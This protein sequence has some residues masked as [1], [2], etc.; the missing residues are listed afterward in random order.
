[1]LKELVVTFL[2]GLCAIFTVAEGSSSQERPTVLLKTNKGDIK[3]ELFSDKAPN[4]VQNFLSYVKS[5][6]YNGT[7]FHRVIDGFMIQGGGMTKEMKDKPTSAPIRNEANNGMKNMRGTLA[8]AR[9]SDVHSATAQFF[10]NVVDNSFLDFQAENARGFGYC[11]FGQVIEGMDVVD[12]IKNVKTKSYGP[13]QNVP[14]ES[15]EI[16][17]VIQLTPQQ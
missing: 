15:I 3:V 10:I 17:E 5:K 13:H 14:A 11:V 2:C 6:Y 4:T 7:I 12:A 9:T 16:L 8:M 1:M